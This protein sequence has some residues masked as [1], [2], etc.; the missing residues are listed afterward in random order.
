MGEQWIKVGL[1]DEIWQERNQFDQQLRILETA[2]S[3][4]YLGIEEVD[5]VACHVVEV[6]PNIAEIGNLLAQQQSAGLG[7][8]YGDL[9]L[10]SLLQEMKIK[11][12]LAVDGYLMMKTEIHMLMDMEPADIGATAADFERMSMDMSMVMKPY[13][14]NQPV[15]IQLPAGAEQA[16]ELPGL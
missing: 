10:G 16:M 11:E 5:G 12:W 2:L 14:Y 6:E 3:V 7:V 1:T 9:D 15:A 8:D 4:S 13:S